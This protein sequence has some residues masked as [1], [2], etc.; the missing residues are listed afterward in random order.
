MQGE[1]QQQQ[2]PLLQGRSSGQR[3]GRGPQRLWG[4]TLNARL[5]SEGGDPGGVEAI[6]LNDGGMRTMRCALSRGADRGG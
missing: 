5:E 1:Q 3:G 6:E 2:Q 4:L